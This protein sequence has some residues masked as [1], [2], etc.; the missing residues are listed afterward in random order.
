VAEIRE[1]E[2]RRW[3][4]ERLTAGPVS[5]PAFG[6]VTVAKAYRL[7]HAIMTTAADDGIIGQRRVA[8]DAGHQLA[9]RGDGMRRLEGRDDALT[10][11]YQAQGVERLP[12][13][14]IEDLEASRDVERRELWPDAGIVEAGRDRVRFDDLAVLVLGRYERESV[15]DAG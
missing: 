11:G 8:A 13:G 15:R 9:Q 12:I 10:S 5:S 14:G 6:P 1:P 4:K 3:H 7:L 2:V